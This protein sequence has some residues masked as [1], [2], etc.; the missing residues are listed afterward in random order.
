M[1]CKKRAMI[2]SFLGGL[3]VPCFAHGQAFETN[4]DEWMGMPRASQIAYV[5]GWLSGDAVVVTEELHRF[6]YNRA[7]EACFASRGLTMEAFADLVTQ[8]W[9]LNNR[10]LKL[11]AASHFMRGLIHHTC[12]DEINHY[13]GEEGLPPVTPWPEW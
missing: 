7:K 11:Y 3:I 13:R 4:L 8:E 9:N 12:L 5:R 1:I 2:L 6:P 10:R